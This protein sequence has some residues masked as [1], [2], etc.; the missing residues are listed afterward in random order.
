MKARPTAIWP[1]FTKLDACNRLFAVTLAA[2]LLLRI[3]AQ[4]GY[5]WQS[6]F[7][8]SRHYLDNGGHAEAG[9]VRVS[10]YLL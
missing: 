8:H 3:D 2:A 10:V 6:G 1:S 7:N 4:L 5:R 9:P